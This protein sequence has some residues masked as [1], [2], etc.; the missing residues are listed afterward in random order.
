MHDLK[1]EYTHI[2]GTHPCYSQNVTN[3]LIHKET[4]ISILSVCVWNLNFFSGGLNSFIRDLSCFYGSRFRGVGN[5]LTAFNCFVRINCFPRSWCFRRQVSSRSFLA[6]FWCWFFS[7][8]FL[9]WNFRF[10]TEGFCLRLPSCCLLG[11]NL[12]QWFLSSF[13]CS[14]WATITICCTSI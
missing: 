4:Q 10:W 5:S 13:L 12:W 3:Q 7:F 8:W 14:Y 11:W 6:T 1:K 9:V 2:R